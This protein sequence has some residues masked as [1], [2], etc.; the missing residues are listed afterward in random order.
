MK[1]KVYRWLYALSVVSG[2]LA[3]VNASAMQNEP[4]DFKGVPWGAPLEDHKQSLSLMGGDDVF[5]HYRRAADANTYANVAAWRISYRF[6][7][8]RFSSATV[9]IVGTSN[10]D[11]MMSYLTKNYGQPEAVSPRHR[12]Y[13]WEGEHSG[14]MTSCDISMSCYIE[15][16]GTQMRELEVAEQGEVP[17]RIK[18][19]N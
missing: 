5:A 16:Y 13:R 4:R 7:K 9:T 8:N 10:F 2:S 17:S 1:R 15:F 11:S 3:C 18:Q 12:I 6:Y 19:D 14:I